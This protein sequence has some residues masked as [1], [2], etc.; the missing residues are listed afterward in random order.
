MTLNRYAT[1]E[2]DEMVKEQDAPS[3]FL[4][5]MFFSRIKE[6]D[7]AQIEFDIVRKGMPLAPFVAPT[8]QGK[9]MRKRGHATKTITPAYIKPKDTVT[10]T[11]PMARTAGE[12]YGGSKT[13]QQR[14]DEAIAE[15][16]QDHRDMIEMRLEWM[17]ASI[18]N[19]G[20]VTIVGEDYPEHLVD[21]GHDPA[22]RQT[23]VGA[24]TWD[25]A[26][27]NP[28]KDIEDM[29]LLIR[30]ESKGARANKLVMDGEAW[31]V[32]REHPDLVDLLNLDVANGDHKVDAGPRNDI[33]GE[34]VGTLSGN[35]FELWV[36]DGYYDDESG[37]SQPFMKPNTVI[38]ASD[39]MDG[40]QYFGAIQ[41]KDAGWKAQKIFSKT[42]DEED[43]SGTNVLS[44]SAPILAPKRV[45]TWGTI[46]VR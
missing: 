21:F 22:L 37:V 14:Y 23:L 41:D 42:W 43:P 7:T 33:D 30:Q 15:C 13:P 19:T 4:T 46:T 35:R 17:A 2:I 1:W 34:K 20:T 24:A 28:M 40:T 39:A 12:D 3:M 8:V 10:G 31:A 16:L 26:T 27:A 9:P 29:A 25:Q 11:E 38:M 44:Q 5:N 6:S 36:Y 32:M 45:N 18:L